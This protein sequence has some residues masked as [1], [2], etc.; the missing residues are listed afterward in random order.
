MGQSERGEKSAV[1]KRLARSVVSGLAV[2]FE[3]LGRDSITGWIIGWDRFH[4]IV[5]D[6]RGTEYMVHKGNVAVLSVTGR[7]AS[8]WSLVKQYEGIVRPFRAHLIEQGYAP[9]H[10]E[11]T[12]C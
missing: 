12:A 1:E 11:A 3:F 10:L 5:L 2:R 6:E 4:W 8:A 9:A 7:Q